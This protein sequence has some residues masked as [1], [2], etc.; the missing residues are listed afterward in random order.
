MCTRAHLL[1][2]MTRLHRTH[3]FKSVTHS[4][5]AL[6]QRLGIQIL[7]CCVCTRG[8]LKRQKLTFEPVPMRSMH[9][10][11]NCQNDRSG[12][13]IEH[14]VD[15]EGTPGHSDGMCLRRSLTFASL[16]DPCAAGMLLVVMNGMPPNILRDRRRQDAI[17]S[18]V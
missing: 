3:F 13:L 7:L 2:Y 4:Q 10:R 18:N 15:L 14:N 12:P 6:S 8:S 1:Q 11:K 17:N 5:S 16:P 9:V